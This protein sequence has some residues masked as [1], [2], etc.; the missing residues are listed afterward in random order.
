ME[1]NLDFLNIEIAYIVMRGSNMNSKVVWIPCPIRPGDYAGWFFRSKGMAERRHKDA[2]FRFIYRQDTKTKLSAWA[3]LVSAVHYALHV[4]RTVTSQSEN[5]V[6]FFPMFFL[7]NAVA[8]VFLPR[9]V[10]YVAMIC[11]GELHRGNTIAFKL[12]VAMIRRARLAICMNKDAYRRLEALGIPKERRLI[13]PNPVSDEF[14]PPSTEERDRAR[15]ALGIAGD[16]IVIGTVG[17]ICERK[18]QLSLLKATAGLKKSR[19]ITVVLCGPQTEQAESSEAYVHQ[20]RDFA[21]EN[22]LKIIETG[23][24]TDVRSVLWA[25]DIFVLASALEGLPAAI[26]QAMACGLPAVASDIPGNRE[27]LDP[28]GEYNTLL[29][30]LDDCNALQ[31]LLAYLC[32][33]KDVR[34]KF[35][36]RN[37]MQ[38]RST[39]SADVADQTY[40]KALIQMRAS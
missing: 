38:F 3:T 7:Y 39:F 22:G 10:K 12:R 26:P 19:D 15:Q 14:R 11:G 34:L 13:N 16:T 28:G 25:L 37:I 9:H 30:P 36:K 20:C 32:H 31:L 27:A 6:V 33:D 18:R 29:F 2:D 24:V 23:R 21:S 40:L 8:A 17:T 35:A 5:A 1:K 4:R